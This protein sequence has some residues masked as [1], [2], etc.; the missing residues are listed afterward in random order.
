LLTAAVLSH[1]AFAE[2]ASPPAPAAAKNVGQLVVT[3]IDVGQG[4]SIFVRAPG[5]KTALIDGGNP[6]SGAL[7]YL[8][9]QKVSRIDVMIATHPHRDHI[10]GLTEVLRAMPVG[11]VWTPGSSTTTRT[12]E[13][14]LDAIAKA[15]VPFKEARRGDAIALGDLKFE[16]LHAEKKTAK[17]NDTSIVARLQHG[18][19]SFLFTGDAEKASENAMLATDKEK[20]ASAI[21]QVG[22]HGSGTASTAPFVAAVSPK[23]AVYSAGAGNSFGHPNPKTVARLKKAGAEVY[24]TDTHGTVVITTDG[25]GYKVKTSKKAPIVDRNLCPSGPVDGK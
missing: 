17:L 12:F 1:D 7:R 14:F 6:G 21:L 22:H 2:Q 23:V 13:R 16:V 11:E 10:G 8:Q 15:K 5:G 9:S 24:G 4:L 20:L 19:V 3:F 25:K 18:N